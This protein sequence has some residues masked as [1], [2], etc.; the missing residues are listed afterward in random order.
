MLAI[1][2]RES[3][4]NRYL[5]L[6]FIYNPLQKAEF[7]PS[8]RSGICRCSVFAAPGPDLIGRNY[9]SPFHHLLKKSLM[10]FF[11]TL[12]PESNFPSNATR[13]L[14]VQ[15]RG[16]L[17]AFSGSCVPLH[18][19]LCSFFPNC[20]VSFS[21]NTNLNQK[22]TSGGVSASSPLGTE[23]RVSDRPNETPAEPPPCSEHS[24]EKVS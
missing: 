24:Q 5:G 23:P 18:D 1:S 20:S 9:K 22:Q 7:Q 8:S 3:R 2:L 6:L 14:R 11:L 19:F 16:G 10:I 4:Q 13:N 21:L 15:H 17:P 12:K